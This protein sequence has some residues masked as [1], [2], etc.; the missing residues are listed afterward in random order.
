M[1]VRDFRF[2]ITG[3]AQGIGAAT[4]RV[5]AAAGARVMLSDI[6]DAAG[7]A[8]AAAIR[9][10]GAD[11]H[12]VHCD[13]TNED[14]IRALMAT[15]DEKLGGIDVLHNNA[16]VHE[17]MID[18]NI[19]LESMSRA[20]FE[21]ILQINLVGCFLCAKYAVPYLRKSGYA[22]IINAGSTASLLGFPQMLAYG[23]SKGGVAMLTKNLAVDLAPDGIRVN[24]YCPA[25]VE[26]NMVTR[27][28]DA[29]PNPEALKS[30][31]ALSHLVPRLGAPE[32]VANL[33]CFLASRE[34]SFINGVLWLIDGGSLAWR[35]TTD[36]LGMQS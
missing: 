30:M 34:A 25:A 32:D 23:A 28:V 31:M 2:V 10:G 19:S 4:A 12:Y 22:S 17:S 35:G 18:E 1:N 26:T 14:Q 3:A 5:A 11:A 27:F 9:E 16:G 6:D 20:T 15:A 36:A 7:E 13:V 8:N 24:G 29:A 33:V 21:R